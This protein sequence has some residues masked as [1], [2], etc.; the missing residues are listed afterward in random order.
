MKFHTTSYCIT[1]TS[2]E[3]CIFTLKMADSAIK[4]AAVHHQLFRLSDVNASMP[5]SKLRNRSDFRSFILVCPPVFGV[6]AVPWLTDSDG[7]LTDS[8]RT[9]GLTYIDVQVTYRWGAPSDGQIG[10]YNGDVQKS[11][12]VVA[13]LD[14]R[15]DRYAISLDVQLTDSSWL[16]PA[17]MAHYSPRALRELIQRY[18]IYNI[19]AKNYSLTYRKDAESS[20]TIE[21]H[22]QRDL[23]S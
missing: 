1:T 2:S 20:F 9:D 7:Q 3:R 13:L 23:H 4:M 17:P 12:S 22:Y 8:W 21:I 5:I 11:A 18:T 6:S 16:V 15:T 14:W 10:V 19:T